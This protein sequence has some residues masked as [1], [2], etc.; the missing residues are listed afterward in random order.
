[1]FAI[2]RTGLDASN[3]DLAVISNNIANAG[4]NGFKRS[5][6][7]FEDVYMSHHNNS[8]EVAKGLGVKTIK[9]RQ[10]FS[11]GSLQQTNGS[12]DI[13]IMGEGFFVLGNPIG[14]ENDNQ[15]LTFTRDG[16]FQLDRFGNIVTT[17]GLPLLGEVKQL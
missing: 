9:P 8:T 10:N 16:S 15:A 4:T 11:Q 17:D 13:A 6:A 12:L 14:R 2:I 1:M 3:R 5:E 7:Q